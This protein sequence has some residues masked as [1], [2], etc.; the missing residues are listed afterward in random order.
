MSEIEFPRILQPLFEPHEYKVLWGGRLGIKSWSIARALLIQ[1]AAKPLRVLCAREIQK[2]ITESVHQL[3]C[4][5]LGILGLSSHFK[6]TDHSITGRNGSEFFFA[7]LRTNITSLKSYE[8]CDRCWVEEAQTVSKRSWNVLIPTIRKPGAEIWASFNP[9]LE[10]DDTYQRWVVKPPPTAWVLKTSWRDGERWMTD[11]QRA[12]M[13]HLKAT[14]P[15]E[16][17]YVYEGVCRQVIEGAIFRAELIAAEKAQR[18]TY[19]PYEPNAPVHT[20]W[21]LGFGDN[22][23]IWFVQSI[24]SEFRLIDFVS[25]SQKALG[26]YLE[27]IKSRPYTYACHWLPH[28]AKNHELS[29]GRTIEEQVRSRGYNVRVVPKVS[30]ANRIEAG[31]NVFGSCWFDADRCAD[32]IQ[33]LRHY[34]FEESDKLGSLAKDP[35][36]DWASHP[37]DAFTYFAVAIKGQAK[38][39]PAGHPDDELALMSALNERDQG[40]APAWNQV[41]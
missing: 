23:S 21:D 17:E 22:T 8:G 10:T 39:E 40:K 20:F 16:Y 12:K 25:D 24:G 37:A 6:V 33:A 29:S 31:R 38:P 5:Q 15:N 3:L 28:D 11:D 18:I 1:A 9:E 19:V 7:G 26:Y 2:S 27:E 14:D 30:I 35:L 34:R 13:A 4:D 36:H 32:G 41:Q